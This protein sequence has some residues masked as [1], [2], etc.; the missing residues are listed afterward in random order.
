MSATVQDGLHVSRN[1]NGEVE[2]GKWEGGREVGGAEE[3]ARATGWREAGGRRTRGRQAGGRNV[4]RKGGLGRPSEWMDA[5]RH[6]KTHLGLY[7][8]RSFFR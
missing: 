1:L 8:W 3:Q 2:A 6:Q 7:K 5:P 4:G